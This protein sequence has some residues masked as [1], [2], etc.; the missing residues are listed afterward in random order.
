M[1]AGIC[2]SVAFDVRA[3]A[4]ACRT[5]RL[6]ETLILDRSLELAG[7]SGVPVVTAEH[8]RA[9]LDAELFD[10]L[11]ERLNKTPGPDTASDGEVCG[12]GSRE[13]A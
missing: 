8:V 9:C 4:L 6:V 2:D 5:G 13:A 12:G 1:S 11:S 10:R 7:R 3:Y